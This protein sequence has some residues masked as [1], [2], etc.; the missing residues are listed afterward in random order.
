MVDAMLT[1]DG[2]IIALKDIKEGEHI[3]IDLKDVKIANEIQKGDLKL[4]EEGETAVINL[5]EWLAQKKGLSSE[6][7]CIIKKETKKAVLVKLNQEEFW[8]PKSEIEIEV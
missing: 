2:K 1:N 3:K 8:L 6:I 7:V 5:P 4:E